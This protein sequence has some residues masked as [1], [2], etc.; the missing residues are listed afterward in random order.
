MLR[1]VLR[2]HP[3]RVRPLSLELARTFSSPPC[4]PAS[5]DVFT[6]EERMLRE[7]GISNPISM[8]CHSIKFSP[9]VRHRYRQAEGAGN[10]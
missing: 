4:L 8:P 2:F 3:P 6:E 7:S 5:L 1:S 9:T 10:G